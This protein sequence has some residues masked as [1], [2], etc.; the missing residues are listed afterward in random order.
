MSLFCMLGAVAVSFIALQPQYIEAQ[1]V[2]DWAHWR[3]WCKWV[4]Q[5]NDGPDALRLA[6]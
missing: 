1:I 2:D 6:A 5:A 3:H 4:G